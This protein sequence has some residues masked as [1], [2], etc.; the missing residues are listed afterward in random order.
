MGQIPNIEKR[1]AIINSSA[2]SLPDNPTKAGFKPLDIK[3]TLY[4]PIIALLDEIDR[5]INKVNENDTDINSTINTLREN[6]NAKVEKMQPKSTEHAYISVNGD[7]SAMEITPFPLADT[8]I[9]RDKNGN[10]YFNEPTSKDHA[11]TKEYVDNNDIVG[12]NYHMGDDYRLTLYL[13]TN[14][15]REIECATIDLPIESMILDGKYR[16][17]TLTLYLNNAEDE[18]IGTK[19]DIDVS[20]IIRGLVSTDEFETYKNQVKQLTQTQVMLDLVDN[21]AEVTNRANTILTQNYDLLKSGDFLVIRVANGEDYKDFIHIL[22]QESPM[23]Y[24]TWHLLTVYDTGATGGSNITVEQE[25]NDSTKPVSSKA[26]KIFGNSLKTKRVTLTDTT[27]E[28]LLL[29]DNTVYNGE[30]NPIS[31]LSIEYPETEFISELIFTVGSE[32]EYYFPLGTRYVGKVPDFKEGET[33]ELNIH[34]GIIASG[35]VVSE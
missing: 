11:A 34:N 19:I 12:F 29:E 22:R 35:K 25:V 4:E 32:F 3:K 28:P 13:V 16:N 33:W 8:I 2:A 21:E 1:Q 7:D 23:A 5:V 30:G 15:G 10:T 9:S 27:T 18:N 24:K 31:M 26:V 20:D 14:S 6:V 17:G